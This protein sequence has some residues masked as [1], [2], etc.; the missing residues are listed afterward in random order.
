MRI[1]Y[2]NWFII[3]PLQGINSFFLRIF[4]V[5]ALRIFKVSFSAIQNFSHDTEPNK[6]PTDLFS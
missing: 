6:L 3:N 2:L 4:K 5:T 1:K